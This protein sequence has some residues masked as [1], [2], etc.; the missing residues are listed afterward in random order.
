MS[1]EKS[2]KLKRFNTKNFHPGFL[3]LNPYYFT[4][5]PGRK[6]LSLNFSNVADTNMF[7][8]DEYEFTQYLDSTT[9]HNAMYQNIIGS[10]LPFLLSIDN[11]STTP[12]DFGM[13]RASSDLIAKQVA[14]NTYNFRMDLT[15]TW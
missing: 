2:N 12:K 3:D 4:N 8:D 15:E 5:R 9:F 11:T 6:S 14:A 1:K 13:F 10:H 7:V